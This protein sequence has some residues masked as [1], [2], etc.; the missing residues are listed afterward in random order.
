[1]LREAFPLMPAHSQ[2]LSSFERE[3]RQAQQACRAGDH[4]R[5]T[6]HLQRA[7]ILGQGVTV[8][9]VR[10]HLELLRMNWRR[11]DWKEVAGQLSRITA[12]AL[13]KGVWVPE[14]NPG[15]SDVSAFRRYPIPADL[16]AILQRSGPESEL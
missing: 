5:A 11:R 15:T 12:A 6:H 7:H 4:S 13:F 9:H 14:G 16:K 10:S 3:L 2:L 1:V 8:L